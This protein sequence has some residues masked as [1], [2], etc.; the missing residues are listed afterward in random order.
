MDPFEKPPKPSVAIGGRLSKQFFDHIKG[1]RLLWSAFSRHKRYPWAQHE[2]LMR[3]QAAAASEETLKAFWEALAAKRRWCSY[4]GETLGETRKRLAEGD[5]PR[6]LRRW[7]DEEECRKRLAERERS[8]S[9]SKATGSRNTEEL[10][11]QS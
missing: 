5:S 4:P 6:Q 2:I 7:L 3:F 11:D 9:P 10:Q 1:D 8:R